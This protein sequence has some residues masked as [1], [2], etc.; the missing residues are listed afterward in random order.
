MP[1]LAELTS[2]IRSKNAGPFV[3]TFDIM[4]EDPDAYRTVKR[5]KVLNAGLIA[6]LFGCE[7]RSVR[8]FE[9]DNALAFKASIPRPRIQGDQGDADLHGGQ[10]FAP[11]MDIEIP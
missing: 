6:Q 7:L 3:M 11:L 1:K 10:Q 5:S 2:L 9:C 8:F 4:F